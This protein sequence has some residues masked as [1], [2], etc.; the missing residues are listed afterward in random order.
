[1]KMSASPVENMTTL[2]TDLFYDILR[3]LD[4]ATLA[5]ASC[6]CAAFSSMSKEEKIW[7]N[8][9]SSMWPS[10]KNDD[11]KTLISSIGGFKKFYADCFP[12]IVNKSVPDFRW[13]D[14]PEYP[15]ELTEAEYYGDFDE[16]E[17]VSPSDFVSIVD[18]RYKDK[19]ICSKVI[20]GIPNANGFNGWF[21]NCP[22]RI[23]LFTFSDRGDED[24][25]G[26]FFFSL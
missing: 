20:W 23:D 18:I 10:T 7:E 17:N 4:G 2:N 15:E 12:L 26:M 9:C 21:S 16:F 6:A 11:V 14:Y 5:S 13:S 3:R 25:D 8:I 24:H 19:T 22:F 1:M